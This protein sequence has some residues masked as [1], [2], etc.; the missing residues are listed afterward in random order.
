M[1]TGAG[2]YYYCLIIRQDEAHQRGGL[3]AF[4]GKT[5][6]TLPVLTRFYEGAPV[7]FVIEEERIR[8]VPS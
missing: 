2:V 5:E 1:R 8:F 4:K 7:V 3:Q 6:R